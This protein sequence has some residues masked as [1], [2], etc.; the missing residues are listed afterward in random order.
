MHINEALPQSTV[1][2]LLLQSRQVIV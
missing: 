1:S 2:I